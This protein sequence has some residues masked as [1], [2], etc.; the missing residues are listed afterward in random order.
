MENVLKDIISLCL[1][2]DKKASSI[3]SKLSSDAD[4]EKL[5]KF[6]KEMSEDEEEHVDFW[7]KLL[8]MAE[9]RILPEIFDRPERTRTELQRIDKKAEELLNQYVSTQDI[10]TSFLFAYKMESYMLH[11]SFETLFYFMNRLSGKADVA[12][13]YKNHLDKFVNMISKYRETTPELKLIGSTLQRLWKMNHQL[14]SRLSMDDTTGI[15][16]RQGFFNV[17]KPV[18][19]LA[20]RNRH[21]VGFMLIDIDNLK[22]VYEEHGPQKGDEVLKTVA[23]ILRSNI[24]ISDVVGRYGNEDFIIFFPDVLRNSIKNLA[25]KL[26]AIIGMETVSN[27]PVTISLGASCGTLSRNV[28]ENA[29]ILIKRAGTCLYTSKSTGKNKVTIDSIH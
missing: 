28:E 26:R 23:Y 13:S 27:I 11:H 7:F 1:S 9:N 15:L 29:M 5:K 6:W 3:Y 12:D 20:E 24:R 8:S 10:K 2:L 4:N 21:N 17:I 25:E 22:K 19:Y 16:N 18:L 14:V